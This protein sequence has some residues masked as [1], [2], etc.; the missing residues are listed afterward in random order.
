MAG[1]TVTHRPTQLW[2]EGV[3]ESTGVLVGEPMVYPTRPRLNSTGRSAAPPSR[4]SVSTVM[5]SLF[6]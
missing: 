5:T 2:V 1:P 4:L 6:R 3:A